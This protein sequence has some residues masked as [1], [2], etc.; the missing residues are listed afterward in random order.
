M[1]L[2]LQLL[3][4]F[5]EVID[6]TVKNNNKATIPANH[7]LIAGSRKI[8]NGETMMTQENSG[9]TIFPKTR[10]IRA[11]MGKTIPKLNKIA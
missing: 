1:A 4:Q 10:G 7:R 2:P 3:S 11:A 6:F 9:I 8:K 5:P